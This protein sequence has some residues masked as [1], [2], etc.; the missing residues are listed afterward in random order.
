M[1]VHGRSV[2]TFLNILADLGGTIEILI[3]VFSFICRY[4]N[5]MSFLTK[6]IRAIYFE[7]TDL[8]SKPKPLKLKIWAIVRARM[9]CRRNQATKLYVKGVKNIKSDLN[10]INMIQSMK[11]LKACMQVVLKQ[12]KQTN[13]L[14]QIKA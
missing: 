1:V 3:V 5:D 4:Y 6:L 13:L 10:L 11:K 7:T 12:S 9:C 2:K 8:N 14:P